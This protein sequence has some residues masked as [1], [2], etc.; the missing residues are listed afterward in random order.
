MEA[1]TRIERRRVECSGAATAA[2]GECGEQLRGTNPNVASN[3]GSMEK[4]VDLSNI[5]LVVKIW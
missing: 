4:I 2:V 3:F 5:C 1:E